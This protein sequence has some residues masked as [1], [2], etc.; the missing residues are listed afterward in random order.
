MALEDKL[1]AWAGILLGVGLFA[2]GF[3]S[4]I[5][6]PLAS[7]ITAQSIIGQKN[8][9]WSP[10]GRNMTAIVSYHVVTP[11]MKMPLKETCRIDIFRLIPN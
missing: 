3:T 5:T 6:A 1:G 4:S 8:S 11:T 10:T 2:A 9:H 7:A